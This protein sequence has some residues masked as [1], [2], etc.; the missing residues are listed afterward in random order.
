[1]YQEMWS[2]INNLLQPNKELI[3]KKTFTK[4][5]SDVRYII[6]KYNIYAFVVIFNKEYYKKR[7]DNILQIEIYIEPIKAN[8][9]ISKRITLNKSIYNLDD[10]KY[11]LD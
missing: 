5:K 2:E 10:I 7:Y 6:K 11:S 3:N 4:Y 1:M 9:I 8:G